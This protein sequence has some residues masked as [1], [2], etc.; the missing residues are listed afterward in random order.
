MRFNQAESTDEYAV[1]VATSLSRH[2]TQP[3]RVQA[4]SGAKLQPWSPGSFYC[5]EVVVVMAPGINGT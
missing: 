2:V 4:Y 1:K 3:L 5:E